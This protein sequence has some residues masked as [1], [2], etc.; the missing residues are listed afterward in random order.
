[1]FC[2][3]ISFNIVFVDVQYKLSIY[4]IQSMIVLPDVIRNKILKNYF[5]LKIDW[6]NIRELYFQEITCSMF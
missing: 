5:K 4:N 1:M 2:L 6:N 3:F